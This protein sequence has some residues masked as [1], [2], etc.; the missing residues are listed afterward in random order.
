LRN[1][2]IQFSAPPEVHKNYP[3]L[4][5]TEIFT[6]EVRIC[7]VTLLDHSRLAILSSLLLVRS[8]VFFSFEILLFFIRLL[9]ICYSPGTAFLIFLGFSS[10]ALI[11]ELK[12]LILSAAGFFENFFDLLLVFG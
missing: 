1:I 9:P 11:D 10:R 12:H 7:P 8:R 6:L 3:E 4:A 2:I 5:A